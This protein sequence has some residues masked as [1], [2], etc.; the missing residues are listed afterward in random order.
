MD[1]GDAPIK[2]SPFGRAPAIAGE[3]KEITPSPSAFGCHL[4]HRARLCYRPKVHKKG[5]THYTLQSKAC[6]K[7][8][9]QIVRTP[10]V[11]AASSN[12]LYGKSPF[13]GAFCCLKRAKR[14]KIEVKANKRCLTLAYYGYSTIENWSIVCQQQVFVYFKNSQAFFRFNLPRF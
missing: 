10:S 4:S 8:Y 9:E 12:L 14:S 13:A 7:E 3:R 5:V 11:F 6:E 2:G 1:I